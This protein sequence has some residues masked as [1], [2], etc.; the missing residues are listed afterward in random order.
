MKASNGIFFVL[1]KMCSIAGWGTESLDGPAAQRLR[2]APVPLVSHA[3]CN[4]PNSY[5]G[6]ISDSMLCAG[7]EM[8]GKDTCKG[9]SGGEFCDIQEPMTSKHW[10]IS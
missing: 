10:G 4:N 3:V 7:Y 5:S 2:E 9:D 1:D 8:G 6:L